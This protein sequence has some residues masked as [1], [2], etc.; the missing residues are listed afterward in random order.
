MS[1]VDSFGAKSTLTVGDTDYE[2]FRIDTV[3][4]F[5]KL[6][7]SLKILL[8][9][10]LRTEDG[11]NV[12]KEQIEALGNW[13]PDAEPNTEIQFTPA[14]VVMQDFTGVPC[15]VDLATMREAV[16]ALGGDPSKINP[17]SP[18]EMVIDHSVI[19]DLFGSEN[20]LERN[21]EIE[22]E[23][24]GER[25]QFLRW[26]QTAFDDFKVVPPG[27]GIVHQ[28]NIEHLAKV[29]YDRPVDGVLRAYPDTCVGTD[30]HTTMVNGLGVLGWGVGGIEAEAAMLGQPVSMLI[31]RVVGFKLT[32]EIPAGVTATDVV[33]TITDM[34]RKHG[35]VGKFVEFYGEGVAQVPLANRATIGNMSPEFGSTAAMFPVD[36]VTLDYLRLTGRDEQTVALVEAYAKAQSLWHDASRE[37]SFSEFMELD[38]STVVPSIAGP[39]RPQDRILLSEAKNQFEK[40]ILNYADAAAEDSVE[41]EGTFPASD[42]GSAPGVEHETV[43]AEGVSHQHE[44]EHVPSMISSGARHAASKPVKVTTPDGQ[45]YLLDNGA[46]TL[47]AITSC[48][49]TSNPSVMIAAGL[50]AKK[51]VDKGLKRKPWV[52]TTLGPGSKVVTD[53]YEKSG[54]D[55]ALEGLDFYTVGYGCTICIGNSGPL[56]EE[57]SAAINENDLAVTAVLSGNRNFEGRISPDV[58]MNYLASPP[59]VV[60]YALAGSMNFDF[61]TDALGKDADGNDVFLKDIWPSPDE[62][63]EVIDHSISREQFIKQ[64]STVFDGDERWQNLPTPT[65]PIFEWDEDSTYV[66][67]APYF[68]G[69]ESTPAPVTD[70]SGARV[71]ATLGDSVTTDHISPAGNIKAGTPAAQYLTEHGVAQK[72][73]NSY[74]SR[75]G[76]HE[77][78]IR[79]TFA[80]IRLKN[81]I[82]AA[83]NDGKVVEGGF[84]RDFTQPGGPQSYIYDASQNYQ[85]QGTPLVVFGG[86]EYGSGSSRDWAAKGTSLLGV[87]AVITESF[88]RIHRSNLIGMGVVPL[89]FP[90]GESWSSLGLDGT[91]IVS[92]TGLEQL[93]EGVT[94]KTVKVVAEPSEFS[95]EGKQTVEFDAV[96]RIDTPGEADYYRNGG[97]LQYVL[98]SLV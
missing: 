27:T 23:R 42:P 89:Q 31:P 50:L 32:G 62:V 60:A 77:V 72:D 74:G 13:N 98:R 66:R 91:E 69:M 43:S 57:V 84:T 7:Y 65:G 38:L 85:A 5:E 63:Q 18:A 87:K 96:V 76:N 8:E 17:L 22:Y 59:L 82:V 45:S 26:G 40:D 6:P 70:I 37:L 44:H 12:T 25:Y 1:T 68:D 10:L 73:F 46:V 15:I 21:V 2:I 88:E 78:M 41:I 39:K 92:I 58:K 83:V 75:R 54:L 94:P 14:R 97:I 30:S 28:V 55:K 93:N 35:V 49:N 16:T 19:A 3:P 61:E 20:A 53:Y 34:L 36:D 24:N 9:N 90:A 11:A 29:I 4:G 33:L 52:K 79:G 48:T 71:M 56:I 95:P 47:A 51:A 80:N 67:K 86:K 64:Y 81:E